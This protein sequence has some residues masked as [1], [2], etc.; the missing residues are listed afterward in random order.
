[1]NK[2]SYEQWEKV[3]S[4]FDASLMINHFGNGYIILCEP[5]S[6]EEDVRVKIDGLV[7]APHKLAIIGKLAERANNHYEIL[8]QKEQ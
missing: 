2:L 7:L 4:V 5:E 8:L 1:M 6:P 3:K